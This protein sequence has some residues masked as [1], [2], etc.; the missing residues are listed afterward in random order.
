MPL[1]TQRPR[2][3]AS[4]QRPRRHRNQWRRSRCRSRGHGASGRGHSSRRRRASARTNASPATS[5]GPTR[6]ACTRDARGGSAR[7]FALN[8][9]GTSTCRPRCTCR[10]HHWSLLRNTTGAHRSP[11][12]SSFHA[13]VPRAAARRHR[14]VPRAGADGRW[15]R[16]HH[17]L[18]LRRGA[19]EAAPGEQIAAHFAHSQLMK[20]NQAPSAR[21]SS[22]VL[23][24]T[25]LNPIQVAYNHHNEDM[26]SAAAF[27]FGSSKATV[28]L[29]W[30]A[31]A[32]RL[33]V[34]GWVQ[35]VSRPPCF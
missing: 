32:G 19:R 27:I 9:T 18:A 4:G 2:S 11:P 3:S 26:E 17:G 16:E 25:G 8:L 29:V 31:G 23:N 24:H 6:H 10:A 14:R 13:Q 20:I 33:G 12:P 22:I 34:R 35:G 30:R 1:S 5:L 21:Y 15:L 7:V 28:R